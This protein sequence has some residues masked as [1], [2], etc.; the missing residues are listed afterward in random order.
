ML[1]TFAFEY[2]ALS[3]VTFKNTDGWKAGDTSLLTSDLENKSTAANYLKST[4]TD[5]SWARD[6]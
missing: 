1:G 6:E 3:S 2:C 5:Y 4:Y